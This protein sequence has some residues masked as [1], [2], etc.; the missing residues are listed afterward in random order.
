MGTTSQPAAPSKPPP[1][2][3][4]V[5]RGP[6][7]AAEDVPAH[8]T[9]LCEA[10]ALA[11]TQQRDSDIDT[12]NSLPDRIAAGVGDA[13]RQRRRRRKRISTCVPAA[14]PR[15][16]TNNGVKEFLWNSGQF[17]GMRRAH[18]ARRAHQALRACPQPAPSRE[19]SSQNRSLDLSE[20]APWGTPDHAARTVQ[21]CAGRT[22]RAG[23]V[24][25]Q[26]PRAGDP[27]KVA[28]QKE[29][30]GCAGRTGRAGR[31]VTDKTRSSS[32]IQ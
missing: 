9:I 30:R 25:N 26:R 12:L 8:Q 21:G 5:R 20:K 13:T 15:E 17:S 10:P 31:G 7:A 19:T 28:P 4:R 1:L 11:P 23:R 18:R 29:A 16:L 2:A 32:Y 6:A 22:G 27:R 24:L 3:V 14:V